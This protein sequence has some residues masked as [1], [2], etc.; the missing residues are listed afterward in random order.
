MVTRNHRVVDVGCDH[1]YVPIYLVQRGISPEVIAMDIK[2]GPLQR[3]REHEIG[4][5]SCRERVSDVV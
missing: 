1:G 3:A 2:E 4:R 5:A